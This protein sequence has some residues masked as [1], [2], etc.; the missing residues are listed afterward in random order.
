M[1][2]HAE[3]TGRRDGLRGDFASA[4]SSLADGEL[5]FPPPFDLPSAAALADN[6]DLGEIAERLFA[7]TAQRQMTYTVTITGRS[8]QH[9][10]MPD[11]VLVDTTVPSE[12]LLIVTLETLLDELYARQNNERT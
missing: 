8:P 6:L 9:P 5:V 11:R 1:S 2:E 7:V 12:N 3:S 4:V 10:E